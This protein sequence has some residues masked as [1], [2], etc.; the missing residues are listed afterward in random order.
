MPSGT[1]RIKLGLPA[2]RDWWRGATQATAGRALV[3]RAAAQIR[4]DEQLRAAAE[5][6]AV[7]LQVLEHALDVVARLGE[8]NP[9]DPVDGIDLGVAWVA[10][11]RDP[12]FHAPAPGI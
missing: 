9:L 12:L 11:F 3:L 7:D 4:L 6:N 2:V 5:A 8:R 1:R 10:V